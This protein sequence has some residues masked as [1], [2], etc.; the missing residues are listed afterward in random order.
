MPDAS[1]TVRMSFAVAAV[2]LL[3]LAGCREQER[4]R[5]LSFTPHQ[6][7]GEKLPALTDQQRRNLQERGTLQR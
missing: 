5:P 3:A 1:K 2:A 6:Y 7:G 4:D